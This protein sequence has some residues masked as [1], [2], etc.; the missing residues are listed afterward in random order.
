MTYGAYARPLGLEPVPVERVRRGGWLFTID[1][2]DE[3]Q[4]GTGGLRLSPG[5]YAVQ[6]VQAGV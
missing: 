2:G 5:G 4:E 3:E 6:K 1:L